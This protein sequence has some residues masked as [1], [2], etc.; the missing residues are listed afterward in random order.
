MGNIQNPNRPDVSRSARPKSLVLP[1]GLKA[2][3]AATGAVVLLVLCLFGGTPMARVSPWFGP[4]TAELAAVF[5][6]PGTQ[7]MVFGCL[8]I[9][10][11]TFTL[12]QNRR[13]G[14]P[15]CRLG[16]PD[17]WLWS[18][19]VLATGQYLFS[20][21]SA[22]S[23]T[24]A[25]VLLAGAALGKGMATWASFNHRN[26]RAESVTP[27]GA[28]N[29]FQNTRSHEP[30]VARASRPIEA[31]RTGDSKAAQPGG[32]GRAPNPAEVHAEGRRPGEE[33]IVFVLVFLLAV[34]ALWPME[35]GYTFQYR[36]AERWSGVWD[37]PNIFGLLT[38]AG[39]VLA[40][41]Q[42][43]RLM[44]DRWRAGARPRE[45]RTL[46]TATRWWG[47]LVILVPAAGIL[48]VGLVKSYSRGAWL[49]TGVA[50]GY[51]VVWSL[52]FAGRRVTGTSGDTLPGRSLDLLRRNWIPATAIGVALLVLAFWSFRD[53]ERIALRRAFSVANVNDFSWRNRVA[54]WEGTL[55]MMADKPWLGSGWNQPERVYDRFYR[56]AQVDE[57]M[58]IQMN[59]YFMLGTTLGIPAL[60]CFAAYLA[61]SLARGPSCGT[62]SSVMRPKDTLSAPGG[63]GE[64]QGEVRAMDDTESG[65]R[66]LVT[67]WKQSPASAWLGITC[68]AGAM[69][70]L[71]G[72]WFDGGLLKLATATVFWVLLE[73]GRDEG[74]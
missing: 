72:F 23:S 61:F 67:G 10:L 5:R 50:L 53:T 34:G 63:R 46:M 8:L 56:A 69:V 6:D 65:A 59:D 74:Q 22:S 13:S 71:V 38:G 14:M 26:P 18:L 28:K 7:W 27:L 42:L 35:T 47:R 24:H 11:A 37:N 66:T 62:P 12:L 3:L 60:V 48:A 45:P 1:I 30:V 54:A 58:A 73:L 29:D 57:G 31:S 55:Q 43:L 52:R 68:R 25:L 51:L 16:N 15:L 64:G 19:V 21:G 41:G 49:A 36:G 40:V 9:Y 44:T 39:L 4:V 70:L 17:A 20:Y 32:H 33:T 2:T